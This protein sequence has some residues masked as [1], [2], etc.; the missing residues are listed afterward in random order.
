MLRNITSRIILAALATGSALASSPAYAWGGTAWGTIRV[1]SIYRGS[2]RAGA[3]IEPA[4]TFTNADNCSN[5]ASLFIDFSTTESPDGKALYATALAA[6]LAGQ[7]ISIGTNG[8]SPD[9]FPLVY[10]INLK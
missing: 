4:A 7:T 8:C 6:Q 10:G 1:L 2:V 9:G 5:P 3:L